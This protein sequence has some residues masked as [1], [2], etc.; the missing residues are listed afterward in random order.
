LVPSYLPVRRQQRLKAT[1]GTTRA[2]VLTTELFHKFFLT[3]NHLH[4]A[5][6]FGFGRI[7][8][9]ALTAALESNVVR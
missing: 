2:Q 9:A 1:T 5:L 4:S 7:T 3:V 8:L 6:H